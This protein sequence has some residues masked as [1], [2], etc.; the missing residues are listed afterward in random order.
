MNVNLEPRREHCEMNATEHAARRALDVYA[1]TDT[2]E[3][4]DLL[5]HAWRVA[6]M[7]RAFAGNRLPPEAI[8]SAFM[9]DVVDRLI[10]IDSTKHT[11]E[12]AEAARMAM[13]DFFTDPSMNAEQHQYVKCLSVDMVRIELESGA[14]RKKMANVAAAGKNGLSE[15]IVEMMSE[16]YDG[17]VTVEGWKNTEPLL[18]F[19]HMRRFLKTVHIES[20]IIKA[21]ELVDNMRNP[22]SQRESA[23]LQDVLEAESFYAPIIEVLGFEGLASTLRGEAHLLRL[24][25]QDEHEVMNKA[26][27]LCKSIEDIGVQN[28]VRRVFGGDETSCATAP[29][30][31]IDEAT[32]GRPIHI[33]E[34]AVVKQDG[35]VISGNYR[36]KSRG[37][38]AHKIARANGD[39][40]MDVVGMMVISDSEEASVVDFADFIE[41]RTG[42]FR[43]HP[44]KS[45]NKPIYISGS[46]EYTQAV[47]TE[48]RRRGVSESAYEVRSESEEDYDLEKGGRG[49]PRYQVSKVTFFAEE[50]GVEI[51]VEMQFLTKR[52]RRRSRLG[53]TAHVIYKYL[54]QFY[55]SERELMDESRYAVE[56]RRA[57]FKEM[58][59]T[60]ESAIETLEDMYDRVKNVSPDNLGVNERSLVASEEL[61]LALAA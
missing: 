19:D 50:D 27:S 33:G 56:E 53:E 21:C 61:R 32:G 42:E 16:R 40:S 24:Y 28:L 15:D 25:G 52:E 5:E 39:V 60:V 13:M 59:A 30:V 9:H 37:S 51:P 36:L 2:G 14:H 38:L 8:S 35:K 12:R 55:P 43:L 7:V 45:K 11:P 20:L 18:D 49:Y 46:T 29:A 47:V 23:M 1:E 4:K 58:H 3:R 10:N 34:F 26:D 44:A 17:E 31:D 41:H 54:R 6:C 57:I 48:L 22:S